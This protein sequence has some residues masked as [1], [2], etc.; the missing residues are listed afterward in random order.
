M[1][2]SPMVVHIGHFD[3]EARRRRRVRH[4]VDRS[5]SCARKPAAAVVALLTREPG[6]RVPKLAG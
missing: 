5:G 3:D 6:E 1:R 2:T 4:R